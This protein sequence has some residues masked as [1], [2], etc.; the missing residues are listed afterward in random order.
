MW[1]E[2]EWIVEKKN[3]NDLIRFV[4]SNAKMNATK[5]AFCNMQQTWYKIRHA[6][7]QAHYYSRIGALKQ[8]QIK[9]D[10]LRSLCFNVPERE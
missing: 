9:L 5:Q 2:D 10:W 6:G 3:C 1:H 8:R 4:S 7:G